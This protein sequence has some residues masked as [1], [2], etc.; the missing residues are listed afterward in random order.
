MYDTTY[1]GY[2]NRQTHRNREQNWALCQ[3]LKGGENGE[4]L[5]LFSGYEVSDMQNK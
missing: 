4:L 1:M 5:L 3:G 2:L